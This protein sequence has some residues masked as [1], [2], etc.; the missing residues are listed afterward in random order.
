MNCF[1]ILVG[2]DLL[3]RRLDKH[4]NSQEVLAAAAANDGYESEE[5]DG[6]YSF[7]LDTRDY[8]ENVDG[9]KFYSVVS[10]RTGDWF[11]HTNAMYANMKQ[12]TGPGLSSK[13]FAFN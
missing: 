8:Q 4:R 6:I 11:V 3:P 9:L 12:A 7:D 2:S 5:F 1:N 13:R 10:E